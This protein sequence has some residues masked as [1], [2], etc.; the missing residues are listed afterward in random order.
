MLDLHTAAF[1]TGQAKS[2]NKD[3]ANAAYTEGKEVSLKNPKMTYP[4]ALFDI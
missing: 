4:Q 2:I 1:M 3:P